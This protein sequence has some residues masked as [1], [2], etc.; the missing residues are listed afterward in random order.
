MDI[1]GN[2][3]P[4]NRAEIDRNVQSMAKK[5][6]R[7]IAIAYKIISP[8]EEQQFFNINSSHSNKD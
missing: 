8:A 6:Y 5:G 3:L 4:I 2:I 1:N 7:V